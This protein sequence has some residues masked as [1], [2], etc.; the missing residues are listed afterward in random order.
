MAQPGE[1]ADDFGQHEWC[2]IA[3]LDVGGMDHSMNQIAVGARRCIEG[4]AM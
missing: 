3:I 1:A 2:A 4:G